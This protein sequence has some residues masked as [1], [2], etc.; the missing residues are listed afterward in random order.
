MDGSKRATVAS[1]RRVTVLALLILSMLVPGLVT[2]IA[3]ATPIPGN[4]LD[5]KLLVVSADGTETDYPG[6]TAALDRMGVPYDKIVAT[7]TPLTAAMLSDAPTHG[8][9]YG[10]VLTTGNLTYFNNTTQS[11]QSAFSLAQWD[12]LHAYQTKFGVRSVTSFTFPEAA[13]GLT[14]IGY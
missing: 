2:A 8:R 7:Q 12:M 9:Y 14:Y 3:S 1:A 4:T 13:Y 10:I 11:W 5:M 6:I